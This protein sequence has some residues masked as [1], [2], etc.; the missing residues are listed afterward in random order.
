MADKLI[1]IVKNP[2]KEAYKLSALANLTQA[3]LEAYIDTNVTTLANA[4]TYL[5]KLSAVVLYLVKQTRL[6]Q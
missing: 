3:Q 5:K 4:K 1:T 2:N 6:D